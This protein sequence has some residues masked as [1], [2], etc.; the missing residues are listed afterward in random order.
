MKNTFSFL[1]LLIVSLF[2][3]AIFSPYLEPITKPS[4]AHA[5]KPEP[6]SQISEEKTWLL[7]DEK[8]T[9]DIFNRL[10]DSV[11][12][13]NNTALVRNFFSADVHE[14]PN[15]VGSGF[16][17]DKDGY[18]VTNFHVVQ[19]A[20]KVKVTLKDGRSFDAKVVGSE[21]RKDIALL[22]IKNGK[23]LP[24]G[25]SEQL[26]DSSQVV[27]GQ[28]SIAIGNPFELSHTLTTGVISAIGRSFPSPTG[29]TIRDMIQTDAAINPGN[30]GG[31]LIDSRG[32]LI[33]MNTAIYSE[34][35]SSSGVGFAV[36]V[37]TI[38][39]VVGQLIKSGK[40]IQPGL[41]I[42]PL[43]E[44]YKR[45]LRYKG[46]MIAQVRAGGAAQKAGLRGGRVTDNDDVELGDII[47]AVD[48]RKIEN[49]DD[50]Y[51]VFEDKKVGDK[52]TVEYLRNGSKKTT[53]VTLE[54]VES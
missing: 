21:P 20:N 34:S 27:P 8:N 40:I 25:F 37:N 23:N 50:L 44:N 47:I 6:P 3:G 35:G 52:V 5:Q 48:G 1:A 54:D 17:W 14:V 32:Y 41:G 30:S 7:Q 2:T 33:G 22:K 18:V 11:V 36:P 19:R 29:I 43:P 26:A 46:L 53:Q 24:K 31:P 10:A 4:L 9:I 39:R 13:V 38:K 51:N 42:V 16:I 15:G 12:F 28:K 45:Y 49:I